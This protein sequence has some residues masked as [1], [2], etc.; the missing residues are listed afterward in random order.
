[1]YVNVLLVKDEDTGKWRLR[2]HTAHDILRFVHQALLPHFRFG[3]LDE[4][5]PEQL[6][7]VQ[8]IQGHHQVIEIGGNIGR[9]SCVIGKLLHNSSNMLVV[10]SD[11]NNAAQLVQNRD[12]CGLNFH[13]EASAISEV[14]MIQNHWITQPLNASQGPLSGWDTVSTIT[15]K[16][17]I[18][19]YPDFASVDVLV[20]DC[21]GA[22]H[23]I[24]RDNPEILTGVSWILI[25]NDF[26][27]VTQK[28]FVDEVITSTGFSCVYR[29][30]GGSCFYNENF[31]EVWFNP[32]PK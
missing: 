7:A 18:K 2:E 24:L 27:E 6:M 29:V 10:E 3:S 26:L 32:T 25:E 15:Y 16:D 12:A 14:P 4:E 8:Y 30:G 31:F 22:F 20:L 28:Q 17:L 11:P 21:E 1:M 13:V 23:D 9:N 5:V 19:K